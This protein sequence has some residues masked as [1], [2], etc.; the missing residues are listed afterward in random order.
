[1]ENIDIFNF[2]LTENDVV[3]TVFTDSVDLYQSRL[4]ELTK[5]RGAYATTE[6]VKDLAGTAV[7]EFSSRLAMADRPPR[8]ML[9]FVAIPV[10]VAIAL[11]YTQ[12]LDFWMQDGDFAHGTFAVILRQ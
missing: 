10:V 1:M 11:S 8:R 12:P 2:E 4:E 6:A 7:E 9:V 3:F 5:E